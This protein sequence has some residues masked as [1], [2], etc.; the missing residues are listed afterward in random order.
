MNTKDPIL[1]QL[2]TRSF[3]S[4][5]IVGQQVAYFKSVNLFRKP[6]YIRPIHQ[7]MIEM[8]DNGDGETETTGEDEGDDDDDLKPG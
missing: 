5:L 4:R 6:R 7:V 2:S 3:D 1:A 8:T